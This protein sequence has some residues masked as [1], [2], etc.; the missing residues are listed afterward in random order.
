MAFDSS[1]R[2]KT[3]LLLVVLVSWASADRKLPKYCQGK[4]PRMFC[5]GKGNPLNYIPRAPPDITDVTLTNI[6][7]GVVTRAMMSNLTFCNLTEFHMKDNNITGLH[8]FAFR[9]LDDLQILDWQ[10]TYLPL[11]DVLTALRY[12]SSPLKTLCLRAKIVS[13][14]TLNASAFQHLTNLSK[15]TIALPSLRTFNANAFSHMLNLQYLDIS[16]SNL[17]QFN[18]EKI[19]PNVT[20]LTLAGNNFVAVPQLCLSDMRPLTP[21]LRSLNL[22]NN[23]IRNL[24]VSSITCLKN[25]QKLSL[26]QNRIEELPNNVFA[27]LHKLHSLH[28]SNLGSLKR[29]GDFAFNS[30]SLYKFFFANNPILSLKR[31]NPVTLFKHTPNLGILDMTSTK[32]D[33]SVYHLKDFLLNL[34]NTERLVLQHT[35]IKELPSGTFSQLTKLRKLILNGNYLSSW[36]SDVFVNATSIKKIAFDGCN[37]KMIKEDTFPLEFRLSVHEIN[38]S[39]NP[40]TCTCELLW[41]RN[42]MKKTIA[43]HSIN[44]TQ[45][46]RRYECRAPNLHPLRLEDFNPTAKSCTPKKEYTVLLSVV[47]TI[48]LVFIITATVAYRYRWYLFYWMSLLRRRRQRGQDDLPHEMKYD[49]FVSYSNPDGD[50]VYDELMG[51]LEGEVG[52][53]LCEH[54]RDFE[55]GRLIVDNVFEALDSSRKTVLVISNEYMKSDWCQFELQMALN[56]FLKQETE[57]VVILLEHVK[58]CHVTST[59]RALM[60][61]TTYI[62]WPDVP[63]AQQVFKQRLRNCLEP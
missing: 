44:F 18:L 63:A 56:S 43:N 21:R 29:I 11:P 15:L 37:I 28:I 62:E 36:K 38:L 42:W 39:N 13:E 27:G 61:S 4:R 1:P 6:N 17:K 53:R 9:D 20:R 48:A 31:F 19:I 47:L 26:S 30:T 3:S 7:L 50:W 45:Y 25:L 55:S 5:D 8:P 59:L 12:V 46:P 14:Q 51:Y 2:M 23:A 22:G 33:I 57:L 41:F 58:A 54:S 32:M 49:A 52:L 16:Q 10:Q 34:K 60:T 24:D 40:F 35:Y